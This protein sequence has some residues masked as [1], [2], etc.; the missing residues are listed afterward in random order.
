MDIAILDQQGELFQLQNEVNPWFFQIWPEAEAGEQFQL[1][2]PCPF[3]DNFLVDAEEHWLSQAEGTKE[4]GAFMERGLASQD[5]PLEARALT[6][7]NRRILLIENL[8]QSF[9]R[10]AKT[11][12]TARNN[13]L[14]QE[15]LE[16]E[17]SK[18]TQEIRQREAE[19]AGRLIYASGFRDEET[20]AHIRRIGLYSAEMGRALGWTQMQIDDVEIAAPMH[21]LGKIGIPDRILKKP[22]ELTEEEQTIM[23]EHPTI[24]AKILEDSDISMIQMAAD[25]AGA[26]HERWD[27]TG[28]PDG[29]SGDSIPITARIVAIVDVYDALVHQRVYKEA[30]DEESAL[31]EMR[32]QS[33]KHFDPVLLELFFSRRETMRA[34]REQV[35]DEN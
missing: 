15:V 32:E 17:V 2:G 11:L 18:R 10:R 26:H 28:Y 21:D 20:G 3:V 31:A 33:G 22:G 12:Q 23:R 35:K 13:L 19:I 27:G 5:H 7:E 30:W 6:V 1:I 4:S 29:I 16:A 24:G 8:G 25:I 14:T 34:I 9:S